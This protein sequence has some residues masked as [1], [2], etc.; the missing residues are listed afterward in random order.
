ISKR[1]LAD[2]TWAAPQGQQVGGW[3]LHHDWNR[4]PPAPYQGTIT[5]AKVETSWWPQ[6]GTFTWPRT[7][8][9]RWQTAGLRGDSAPISSRGFGRSCRAAGRRDA[10]LVPHRGWSPGTKT[11]APGCGH[12]AAG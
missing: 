4:E 9:T 12:D 7:A 1:S 8:R 10:G 11:A 5:P 2:F 6:M 3:H